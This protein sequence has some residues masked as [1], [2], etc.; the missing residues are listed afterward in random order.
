MTTAPATTKTT[1]YDITEHLRTP[2]EMAAYLE[3]TMEASEGNAAAIA[4]ALG[5]IARAPMRSTASL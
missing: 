5:D 1:P 3:A 2:Q 4:K